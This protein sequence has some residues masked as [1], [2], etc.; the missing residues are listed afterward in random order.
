MKEHTSTGMNRTGVQM[1]PF[2]TSSMQASMPRAQ[3]EAPAGDE[4][5]IA[6]MRISYIEQAEPL[7]SVPPPGT[8]TGAVSTGFSMLTGNEPQLLLDKL[9]ERVTFER[10]GVRIY[11]AMI[12]K[13]AALDQV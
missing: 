7:G 11:D 4:S 6:K 12:A 10:T 1:S 13:F 2:D 9:S 8:I 3:A 5:A